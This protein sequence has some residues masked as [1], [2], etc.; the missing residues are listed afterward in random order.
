MTDQQIIQG[1][2]DGDEHITRD[3]FYGYCQIAYLLYDG[4]WDGNQPTNPA[5]SAPR[6]SDVT[7]PDVIEIVWKDADGNVTGISALDTRCGEMADYGTDWYTVDG[8]K[9]DGKPA[10]KGLYIN[11]GRKV[12]VK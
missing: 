2:R 4:T 11:N 9:L 5:S 7:L 3:Y 12:V 8:R 10:T 1:F 6:R